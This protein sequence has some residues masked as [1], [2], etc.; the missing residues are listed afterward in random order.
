MEHKI[1]LRTIM[2]FFLEND[3]EKLANIFVEGLDEPMRTVATT[4]IIESV[5]TR[6]DKE[7]IRKLQ[8]T[9]EEARLNEFKQ[10][11]GTWTTQQLITWYGEHGPISYPF[12]ILGG[13]MD[14]YVHCVYHEL[15]EINRI[16][17]EQYE[18]VQQHIM[19]KIEQRCNKRVYSH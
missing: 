18:A 15:F 16:P 6:V 5:L 4:M 14:E 10:M 13:E 8:L 9:V 12:S 7:M 1:S 17:Q 11:I 2:K 3:Q 19:R